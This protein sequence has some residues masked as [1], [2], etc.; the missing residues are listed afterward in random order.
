MCQNPPLSRGGDPSV[1]GARHAGHKEAAAYLL[2][3]G[4]DINWIGW[5]EL[6]T[7]DVPRRSDAD[8][9]AGWLLALGARR[10]RR[11][12]GMDG[13]RDNG[14][15]GKAAA[16]ID[17]N[18]DRIPSASGTAAYRIP[19]DLRGIIGEVKNVSYLSYTNQLRD[20]AAYARQPRLR[21]NLYVRGST[22]LSGPLQA[23]V[24]G[25][26]INLVRNLP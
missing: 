1:W 7:L 14:R 13:V 17:R 6:T 8:D 2:E 26:A 9:V 11:S 12:G 5:D 19:D 21:F 25:G 22:T 20:F 4:A 3:R 15:E 16:G 18:A 10:R 23:A 24:D